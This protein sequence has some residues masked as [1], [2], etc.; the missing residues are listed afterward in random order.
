MTSLSFILTMSVITFGVIIICAT[1]FSAA[2]ADEDMEAESM[3]VVCSCGSV[4]AGPHGK[5]VRP[6]YFTKHQDDSHGI[7]PKC[8]EK[9]RAELARLAS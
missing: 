6:I 9:Y 3:R 2:R 8:K 5:W 1:M 7:C 4:Q